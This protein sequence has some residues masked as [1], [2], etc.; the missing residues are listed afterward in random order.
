MTGYQADFSDAGDRSAW[1]N[2]YEERGRG[3]TVMKSP[4]EGWRIAHSVVRL[5][6]WNQYEILAQGN[7]IRLNLNG[8]VTIDTTDD[9]RSSGITALQLHSGGADAGGVQKC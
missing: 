3:R 6:D 4:V 2:F 5:R 9:K 1:G 8:I 7:H